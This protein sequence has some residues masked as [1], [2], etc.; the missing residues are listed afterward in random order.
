M[1]NSFGRFGIPA[2]APAVFNLG[3]IAGVVL[4]Y[5]LFELPIYALAVGVLIGGLG[6]LLVQVPLLLRTGYRFRFRLELLD[7]G[8]KRVVRLFTPMVVGMSASRVNILV[9]TIL[10]SFLIEGA[11]S[12]LNY[13]YRLM[14]FPL[15][16]FAVALGTVALPR[17]SE[18]VARRDMAGVAKTYHE[19]L[20]VNLI[21]VIPSAAFL[22][23]W[24]RPLVE[25]IYRWGE[26]V[27]QD[28]A[29]T[30]LALLHYSYGLIGFAAVRVT[31]PVYYALGDA[32]LPMKVSIAAVVLNILLY[33]PLI[34]LL[35]FAGLAAA[36]SL[37]GLA[38]IGLLIAFLPKRGIPVNY[39]KLWLSLFRIA[40]AA[41]LAMYASRLFPYDFSTALSGV[42][43]RLLNLLAP[44]TVGVILYL[45]MLILFR[46][47]ELG[48][49]AEL[50]RRRSR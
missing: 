5:D 33:L 26:F 35:G 38:N 27:Q 47:R 8:F 44:A 29:N 43:A 14:H 22:A 24:G 46:V 31:V 12:Y 11:I 50:I 9:S 19:T 25:L 39:P 13:S 23:L 36:T 34:K 45:L 32:R 3:T 16:V 42:W 10:A 18:Q 30:T 15:G 4:L 17:V 2:I 40:L 21:L 28:A 7:E 41:V 37:A 6:Q 49:L 48:L 20:I 1:L